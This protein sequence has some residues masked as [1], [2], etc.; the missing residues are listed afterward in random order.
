MS[1]KKK[2]LPPKIFFGRPF[3]LFCLAAAQKI[4]HAAHSLS[5]LGELHVK[6]GC[7][8]PSSRV[9]QLVGAPSLQVNRPLDKKVEKQ[10]L[11]FQNR[12]LFYNIKMKKFLFTTLVSLLHLQSAACLCGWNSKKNLFERVR[13]TINKFFVGL[14]SVRVPQAAFSR[15]RSQFYCY[16]DLPAGK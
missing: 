1:E 4:A 5:R 6:A 15:P 10:K 9:A 16:T 7:F 14:G 2:N 11:S 8:N 3:C 12:F 13:K